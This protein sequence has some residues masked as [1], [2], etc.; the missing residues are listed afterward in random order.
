MV[1]WQDDGHLDN[2]EKDKEYE[3][4]EHANSAGL[5]ITRRYIS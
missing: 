5:V 1:E 3:G 4:E 2:H